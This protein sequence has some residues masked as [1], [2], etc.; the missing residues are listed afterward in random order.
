MVTC[1]T[2]RLTVNWLLELIKKSLRQGN[3]YSL[4]A[5]V[6]TALREDSDS[7]SIKLKFS[8]EQVSILRHS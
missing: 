8:K 6:S 4:I 3:A 2:D 7:N 5:Q 1:K